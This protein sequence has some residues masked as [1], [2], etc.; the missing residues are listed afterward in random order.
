VPLLTTEPLLSAH[1]V[2]KHFTGTVALRGVDFE[3][4]PGEI[5]A[6]VGENGAGKSTLIKI[7]AGVYPKDSGE[8]RFLGRAVDPTT[9][10][11]PIAFIHQ[12]LGLTPGMTV[13]ENI[14]IVSGYPKRLGLINW[15]QVKANAK[16][17]LALMGAELPTGALVDRLSIAER[18]I[19]ALARAMWLQRNVVVLDEPTAALPEHDV[20]RLFQV[21]RNIRANGVGIVYVTH[22]LEEVFRIADRTTVLRDGRWICTDEVAQSTRATLVRQIT[23]R[24][25]GMFSAASSNLT[26]DPVLEVIDLAV[27]AIGP[28]SFVLRRGEILGLVGLRGAGQDLIGRVVNG[29]LRPRSGTIKVDG[30]H[31]A[32]DDIV[33]ALKRGLGFVSSRRTDEGIAGLLSVRE[34]IFPN[35]VLRD[36]RLFRPYTRKGEARSCTKLLERFSIRPRAPE[37]I[38]DTLSGGNQQKVILAR[39]LGIPGR[40]ILIL[41][42]PTSGVDV[43][44]RYEIYSALREATGLG[45]SVLLISSDFEEVATVANRALVVRDGRIVAEFDA[46]QMTIAG[47]SASATGAVEAAST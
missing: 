36:R 17:V 30:E 41:E 10:R 45:L 38:V 5:H 15:R 16:N 24:E 8:I 34:N 11:L 46:G 2:T 40:K 20:A 29:S 1:N 42:E 25:L 7:F 31:L 26:T 43:G 13:A 39:W 33:T 14:A 19:V 9:D 6:L 32:S 44:A 4:L 18:S 28:V 23:G 35:P 3:V 37:R 47:L 12:D 21:L 22:R 27:K